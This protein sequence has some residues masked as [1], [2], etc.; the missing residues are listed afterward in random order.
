MKIKNKI[1]DFLTDEEFVRW[2]KNKDPELDVFWLKWLQLYPDKREEFMA[3][4]EIILSMNFTTHKVSKEA[5][6]RSLNRILSES[7]SDE[8]VKT[9]KR[10]RKTYVFFEV[11]AILL[12]LIA[13]TYFVTN[14]LSAFDKTSKRLAISNIVKQNPK[15][16]KSIIELPDGTMV[17]LNAGSTLSYPSKFTDKERVINLEGQAFFDVMRDTLRPFRVNSSGLVTTALGT[18]FDVNSYSDQNEEIK[19][20]LVS[21]KINI[22][23][24]SLKSNHIAVPG[25]QLVYSIKNQKTSVKS[26][27]LKE[28]VSWRDGN[29]FFRNATL[30]EVVIRLERWYGV[31]IELK[32]RPTREWNLTGEFKRQSLERVL[33]RLSFTESFKYTLKGKSI[34][35]KF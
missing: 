29:L 6:E 31:D 24:K 1:E 22:E 11:A 21:G 15:G 4:R 16:K 34:E 28:V 5:E 12:C 7:S 30:N 26:F 32:N 25:E 23:N 33:E 2:V 27:D 14:Y 10:T 20:S 19:I 17:W 3:A 13:T 35:I 9:L 8:A 18:S